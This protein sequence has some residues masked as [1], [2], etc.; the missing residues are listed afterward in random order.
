MELE[1]LKLTDKRKEICER[2]GFNSSR[3]IISYYPFRYD[4]YTSVAYKDFKIGSQVCF[5]GELIT[6]P[7]TYKETYTFYIRQM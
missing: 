7:S 5:S 4:E 1:K 3:D 2:L 6:Y